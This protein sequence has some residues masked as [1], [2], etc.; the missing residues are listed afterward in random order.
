MFVEFFSF[1]YDTFLMLRMIGYVDA[2][3]FKSPLGDLDARDVFYHVMDEL[4]T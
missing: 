1:V 4:L 3:L 2:C